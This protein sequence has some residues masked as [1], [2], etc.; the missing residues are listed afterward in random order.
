[1]TKKEKGFKNYGLMSPKIVDFDICSLN[2]G[3][4]GSCGVD[5]DKETMQETLSY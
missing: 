5:N 3:F 4:C 1:M 2:C